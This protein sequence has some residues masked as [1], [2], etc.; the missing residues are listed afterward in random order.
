M[1]NSAHPYA[2]LTVFLWSLAYPLTR[3]ALAHFSTFSLGFLRYLIASVL[4]AVFAV[5]TKMKPP[6]KADLPWFL[7]SGAIGF[8]LYMVAFNQGQSMVTAST[9]SVIVATAPVLTTL[10]ARVFYGERP[11]PIQWCATVI[12]FI[13]VAVLMLLDGVFSVNS[14]LL[15]LSAAALALSGYNLLQRKLTQNYTAL[16]ASTYSI[17]LGTLML[18]VFAPG[19]GHQMATAPAGPMACIPILGV[20]SSAV[21][22]VAWAKAF[23]LAAKTSQVSNYM[24][25]TPFLASIEGFLIAGEI[26]NQATV[27]GGTIILTGALLFNFGERLIPALRR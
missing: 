7:A 6:R 1:K 4:L 13:G 15:W 16:Q 20:G 18:A 10:M 26:P 22:Y 11:R 3:L 25:L 24:F 8:F 21:A 9:A 17:F 5:V 12:E 23:S 27:L 14:G 19:S 2:A